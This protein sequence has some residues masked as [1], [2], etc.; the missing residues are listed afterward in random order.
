MKKSY[1]SQSKSICPI[2]HV[3]KSRFKQNRAEFTWM[4]KLKRHI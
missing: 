4:E 1:N 3:I 2:S